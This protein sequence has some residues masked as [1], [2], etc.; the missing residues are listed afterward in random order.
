MKMAIALFKE[1]TY[2]RLI[3]AHKCKLQKFICSP[4]SA[5]S[6]LKNFM[7]LV[8]VVRKCET[9]FAHSIY[10]SSSI[11]IKLLTAFELQRQYSQTQKSTRSI[12]KLLNSTR[13]FAHCTVTHLDQ[14]EITTFMYENAPNHHNSSLQSFALLFLSSDSCACLCCYYTVDRMRSITSTIVR[15]IGTISLVN[16]PFSK[17]HTPAHTHASTQ[18]HKRIELLSSEFQIFDI[19]LRKCYASF[20]FRLPLSKTHTHIVSKTI[21]MAKN[22][23]HIEKCVHVHGIAYFINTIEIYSHVLS[24]KKY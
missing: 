8:I 24:M 2:S 12:R 21:F 7:D 11:S 5:I 10:T 4:K 16:F 22:F 15:G 14:I 1:R 13:K 6:T 19:I 20:L 23:N 9:F 3:Q 18:N 17:C